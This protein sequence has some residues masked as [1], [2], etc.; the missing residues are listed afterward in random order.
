MCTEAS[1]LPT[2]YGV[3]S[4]E[5]LSRLNQYE[6]FQV[7]EL[8]CYAS[9]NDEEFQNIPWRAY[10]NKPSSQEELVDYKSSSTNEYGNFRFNSTCLDYK[11]DVVFDIRDPW[12]FEH[13]FISPFKRFFHHVIMPTVDSVP[14]NPAWL[15]MF[16]EA[17][18]VFCYSE[19]GYNTLDLP[20]INLIGIASPCASEYFK[21]LNREE[22]KQ[23]M[24]IQKDSIVFGTVMRNQRRKLFPELFEAFSEVK[25]ASTD[26][27]VYLYCHTSHPD[28]GWQIPELL[29]QHG[30]SS[31]VLFTYKCTECGNI[32][33]SVFSDTHKRCDKCGKFTNQIGGLNNKLSD[34]ELNLVYNSLDIYVQY[35]N[36]EGFG[37]SQVEAAQTGLPLIT[38]G[39]SAMLSVADTLDSFLIPVERYNKES[40]TGCLR[41]IPNMYSAINLMKK[42][43]DSDIEY[44]RKKGEQTRQ[45]CLTHY[46]WDN[47]AREWAE[48]FKSLPDLHP[49]RWNSDSYM[50]P[51]IPLN[52]S[53]KTVYDKANFL[54]SGVLGR[55]DLIGGRLWKRI[56]TDLNR[57]FR[58]ENLDNFYFTESH[59]QDRRKTIK[60]GYE[61]AYEEISI[62]RDYYNYWEGQR[63]S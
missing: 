4:K 40:E 54:I 13:Q 26:K 52:Q 37:M 12:M 11:P 3:Y 47:T 30:L 16:S 45:L 29:I 33:A 7:A 48:Y 51:V 28:V 20:N 25:K 42:L 31:S 60:F 9:V 22:V 53:M 57:G 1:F 8:S 14:Q 46:N 32:S 43:A 36:S 63:L 50:I 38:V 18:G 17:T 19:F 41:A 5:V 39:Y 10:A 15:D 61:E 59:V 6:D 24:G 44:L 23:Q 56:M 62:L 34:E 49:G 55:P 21:P 2:G 35:A 27:N 58:M